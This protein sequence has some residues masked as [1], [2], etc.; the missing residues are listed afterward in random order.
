MTPV[1]QGVLEQALRGCPASALE[2]WLVVV[3]VVLGRGPHSCEPFWGGGMS[4]KDPKSVLSGGLGET[5]ASGDAEGGPALPLHS[6]FVFL[7]P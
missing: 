2:P 4:F 5:T 3:G 1:F 6:L 7:L